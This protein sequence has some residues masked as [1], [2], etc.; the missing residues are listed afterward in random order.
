LQV[1]KKGLLKSTIVGLVILLFLFV[2]IFTFI[3]TPYF[4]TKFVQKLATR[5]SD[6]TDFKISVGYLNLS[7]F[8]SPYL[9]NLK[10]YDS[11]DSLMLALE[12]M[13]IDLDLWSVLFREREIR[14]DYVGLDNLQIN[15]IKP[16][17][18]SAYNI[19]PF[20]YQIKN[21]LSSG[22]KKNYH[23]VGR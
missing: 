3:A 6:H 2:S 4:Q 21:Y 7:W 5:I 8:D 18:G 14:L 16:V 1:I 23:L 15:V 17:S 22:K 13:D 20:A 9:E 12:K 10:V 11:Q 19:D